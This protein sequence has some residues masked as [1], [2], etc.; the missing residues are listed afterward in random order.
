METITSE[1]KCYVCG[2]KKAAMH[3]IKPRAEGGT[4]DHR[5]LIPLCKEHH[6]QLE[7]KNWL[8][9][10][11]ARTRYKKEKTSYRGKQT[12]SKPKPSTP[13]PEGW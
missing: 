7:G 5:N 6:D 3:H 1:M 8:G 10:N 11:M 13:P 9:F 4:D 2:D 12:P